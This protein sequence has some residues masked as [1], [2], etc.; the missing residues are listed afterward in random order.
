MLRRLDTW[1]ANPPNIDTVTRV[2]VPIAEKPSDIAKFLTLG[3]DG[4]NAEG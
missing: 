4:K 1:S 3:K 2:G